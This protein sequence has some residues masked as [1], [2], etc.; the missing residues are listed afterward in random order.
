MGDLDHLADD[1][2]GE[3]WMND[4]KYG[5][6]SAEAGRLSYEAAQRQTRKRAE[7]STT[8]SPNGSATRSQFFAPI[9]LPTELTLSAADWIARQ[10]PV[11]EPLIG[12]WLTKTSR[13]LFVAETG[14]GK[15]LLWMALGMSVADGRDFLHWRGSGRRAGVLYVDGEMSSRLLKTRVEEEV[16]R[17]GTIPETFYALSHEDIPDFAPLNTPAGQTC[18]ESIISRIGSID[19][20]IFDSVMCLILGD[21]KDEESWQKTM[22]WVRSLT[23]KNI[24]QIWIH[25]TGHDTTRSYGTK[26]REWQMDTVLHAEGVARD[27]TDVSFSLEFRK[28]RERTPATRADFQT[29][30]VAL[31][32]DR[33]E[34]QAKES[35]QRQGKVSPKG[36]KFLDALNNVL[37][38]EGT[39]KVRGR[40]AA[41]TEAESGMLPAW[42]NRP[43]EGRQRPHAVQQAPPRACRCQSH[44][45]RARHDMDPIRKTDGFGD[46]SETVPKP[47]RRNRR[48]HAETTMKPR[49]NQTETKSE[50]AETIS[51]RREAEVSPSRGFILITLG[52]A[53]ATL[54]WR[55]AA[56]GRSKGD[57]A[58]LEALIKF[59]TS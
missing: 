47:S 56:P 13:C 55:C 1:D 4:K 9:I 12:S 19:L 21:M 42:S 15:T 17:R 41:S 23:S 28:A 8:P 34:H 57:N 54:R 16:K 6:M 37:A 58:L 10:M 43:R 2:P 50:T 46:P 11:P 44:R 31:V 49:R 59:W 38:S 14:L 35:Q 30:R 36:L 27:D 53:S 29:V 3:P 25:H 39:S 7:A 5:G 20:V 40:A 52:P 51:Y 24:G 48:N 33:W 32:A 45:L 22:P 26:T 18:I